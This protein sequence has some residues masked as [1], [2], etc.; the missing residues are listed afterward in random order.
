VGGGL[1]LD[2]LRFETAVVD[3]RGLLSNAQGL[4]RQVRPMCSNGFDFLGCGFEA[5]FAPIGIRQL[6]RRFRTQPDGRDY[7]CRVELL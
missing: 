6:D 5:A 3:A 7:C 1:A 2:A 4:V